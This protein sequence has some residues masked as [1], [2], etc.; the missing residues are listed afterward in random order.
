LSIQIESFRETHIEDAAELFCIR[1]RALREDFPLLP[2]RYTAA[3]TILPMLRDLSQ[4]APGVVA[5]D[6]RK[7][8]GFLIGFVIPD[9][10]GKRSVF[11]PEWAN[12]ARLEDSRRLYQEMYGRLS[13]GWVADKCFTHLVSLLEN[14]PQGRDAWHWLGFGMAAVDGMRDLQPVQA[15]S[16]GFEFRRATLADVREAN[17]FDK[18]LARHLAAPPTFW[19][20]E[21]REY[22][23]WL[24]NSA[25]ALWLAYPG[26]NLG[27]LTNGNDL[28]EAVGCMALEPGYRG[29]CQVTQDEKTISITGAFTREGT[30][31]AGVATALLNRSLEWARTEGYERCAVDFEP[32]NS[33]AARF[34]PKYFR[35]VCYSLMRRVDERIGVT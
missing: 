16:T 33:L 3:E 5:L 27:R 6:G 10:L 22:A 28:E 19:P 15:G 29:G 23:E 30:R 17:L 7:L 31:G 14:D 32:M 35:T 18:A 9:F 26:G 4:G 2:A 21:N 20:H 13:A 1:Y 12:A 8:T 34:W 24:N 11:S 25:N